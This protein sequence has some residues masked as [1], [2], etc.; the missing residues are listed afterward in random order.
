[1]STFLL[2]WN[3]DK[4]PWGGLAE[5]SRAVRTGEGSN[6]R[7]SC[8]GTKQIRE[9]DRLFFLKQ[10]RPPRGIV[11]SGHATS[12]WFE[13]EHWDPLRK[14]TGKL[15]RYVELRFDAL[16]DPKI[17]P[18]L[19]V[20][21]LQRGPLSRVHWTTQISGIRIP[22]DGV[23][24]LE[25]LWEE[26]LRT[27]GMTRSRQRIP[28]GP[29]AATAWTG[30]VEAGGPLINLTQVKVVDLQPADEGPNEA[31][32]LADGH[33]VWSGDMEVGAGVMQRLHE[34][35]GALRLT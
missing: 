34:R 27:L 17:H 23:I 24:V 16:L 4:W 1:V 8:D 10:G 5:E 29:S 35:L 6:A 22:D 12:E 26:H 33:V 15:A 9:G 19:N 21:E 25:Q 20:A 32:I 3:P 18:I 13:D 7:W 14:A 11:A 2:T 28:A 31:V 30:W